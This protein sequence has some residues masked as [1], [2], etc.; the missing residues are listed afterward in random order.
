MMKT[1]EKV[2]DTITEIYRYI[3][4]YF[5]LNFYIDNIDLLILLKGRIS[6]DKINKELFSEPR[7]LLKIIQI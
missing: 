3:V 4:I 1:F 5:S 7:H 6:K 2:Q